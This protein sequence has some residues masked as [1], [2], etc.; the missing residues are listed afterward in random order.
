MHRIYQLAPYRLAAVAGGSFVAF[1]WTIFPYPIS[2]RSW[3]RKDLGSTLFLLSNYYSAVHSTIGARLHDTEG[4]MAIKTSPGRQLK[5]VRHRVFNKLTMLLPSLQQH[6]D[7]QKWEISIG[8]KFPRD[9]YE[10]IIMR[11]HNITNYLSLMSYATDAWTKENGSVYPN[12]E[13]AH[14]RAWLN[15][16]TNLIDSVGPTSHQITSILSLLSSSV[17]QG[18]PLPPHIQL[19]EPY[20]L[21]RRLEALDTGILDSRHVEEPG[22]SAYGKKTPFTHIISRFNSS[23][24]VL[25]VASSLITDDLSR[26]VDHVRDLVGE[27]D[28]SFTVNHSFDSE[29]TEKGKRD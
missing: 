7:W 19:P 9:N 3:L 4:D 17:K 2:D 20:N 6:A 10:A 26:L 25:Q 15:D 11:A 21:S 5:K 22:Y 12:S 1:I 14:R 28:F 29:S 27:T 8:G 16:L 18:S 24:A 13:K 23:V